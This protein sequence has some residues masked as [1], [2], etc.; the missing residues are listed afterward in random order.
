MN[1]EV[2]RVYVVCKSIRLGENSEER[3]PIEK[4]SSTEL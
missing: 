2:V 1:V 4:M 3:G